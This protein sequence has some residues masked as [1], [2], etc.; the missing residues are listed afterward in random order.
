MEGVDA[1]VE[2]ATFAVDGGFDGERVGQIGLFLD[3]GERHH[4]FVE[5]DHYGGIGVDVLDTVG[6]LRVGDGQRQCTD[7]RN[8]QDA[9]ER[10]AVLCTHPIDEDEVVAFAGCRRLRGCKG[11]LRTVDGDFAVQ[12]G[13]DAKAV[14][15]G[16]VEGAIEDED[17]RRA[18]PTGAVGR[19]HR[20]D[21]GWECV[22]TGG[23]MDFFV[24]DAFQ[25]HRAVGNAVEDHRSLSTAA[26]RGVGRRRGHSGVVFA[27]LLRLDLNREPDVS[28]GF[29]RRR[30]G[31]CGRW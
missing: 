20:D 28:A 1:G 11:Q 12:R 14:H 24:D 22:L 30:C 27:R 8:L 15:A 6:G 10:A 7:Q 2:P 25:C 13:V 5:N 16:G 26:R 18:V 31:G 21:G 19:R 3:A 29:G 9:D 23:C 17:H 4:R